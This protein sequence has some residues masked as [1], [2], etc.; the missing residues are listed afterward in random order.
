MGSASCYAV[1]LPSY[2]PA[3]KKATGKTARALPGAGVR[4][5]LRTSDR[6]H[7]CGNPHLLTLRYLTRFPKGN[8]LPR[9]LRDLAMT[10]TER[11]RAVLGGVANTDHPGTHREYGLPHHLSGLVRNDSI[12]TLPSGA[13]RR[14]EYRPHSA[15]IGCGHCPP[16]NDIF[17]DNRN[18]P[19]RVGAGG[20]V[21][22]CG[23]TA[24]SIWG[25]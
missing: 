4:L 15:R 16:R 20:G 18:R 2:H 21:R 5:S 1:V 25:R 22:I 24:R 19:C 3:V 8:G 11:Y 12:V 9:S 10:Y 13:G 14:G 7:W 17:S 23:R 6:C